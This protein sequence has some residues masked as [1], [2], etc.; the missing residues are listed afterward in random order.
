M[1]FR[2]SLLITG[3]VIAFVPASAALAQ[4]APSQQEAGPP[5]E[6]AAPADTLP[7]TEGAQGDIVVTGIRSSLE[8]AAAVKQNSVQVV[9]SIV[10]EDIGKLPD[11]TT[12]AA[13]R[14]RPCTAPW[15]FFWKTAWST[16][17]PRSMPSSAAATPSTCIRASS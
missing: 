6:T 13:L 9:D 2:A 4:Q 14:R 1:G 12:A 16:A 17:S 10:A 3:S 7:S 11:P 15:I 5:A 8:K